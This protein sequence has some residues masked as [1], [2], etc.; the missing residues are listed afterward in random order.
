MIMKI[1]VSTETKTNQEMLQELLLKAR[2]VGLETNVAQ[3]DTVANEH[4]NVDT[5][6]ND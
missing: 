2:K 6:H 3:N 5:V 4:T 1:V